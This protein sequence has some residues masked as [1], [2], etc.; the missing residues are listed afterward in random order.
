MKHISI[1]YILTTALALGIGIS[2][3]VLIAALASANNT[4]YNPKFLIA[5]LL[6]LSPNKLCLM[7]T[8][9]TCVVMT[10]VNVWT[11]N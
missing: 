5:S 8:Q 1:N 7:V 9:S 3:P 10:A 11:A 6:P 2:I 4:L